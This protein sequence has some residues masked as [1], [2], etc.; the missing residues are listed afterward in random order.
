MAFSESSLMSSASMV[1]ALAKL[2]PPKVDCPIDCLVPKQMAQRLEAA[3]VK[4][5]KE[6]ELISMFLLAV[7]AGIFVSMGAGFFTVVRS[8]LPGF[9]PQWGLLQ[10]AGGL[11]F[12]CGL[13]MVILCGSELFTGN[14]M[15]IMAWCTRKITTFQMFRNWV[16]VYIGNFLGSILIAAL[17]TW[18]RTYENC[19]GQVGYNSLAIAAAKCGREWGQCYSLGILCN[20]MVCWS[21]WMTIAARSA[22]GK[23]L[24]FI[25][26]ITAFAAMGFEHSVA[27]MYFLPQAFLIRT[28]APNSFWAN[29]AAQYPKG[30]QDPA[31]DNVYI[32]R[33][34]VQNFIPATLGNWSGA[35]VFIAL[36]YWYLYLRDAD[37]VS[38]FQFQIGSVKF[39]ASPPDP[40]YPLGH[41]KTLPDGTKPPKKKYC[42]C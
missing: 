29:I 12:C 24:V 37:H 4:K 3:S 40:Y 38:L 10:F 7:H 23:T 33:C 27:N 32:G 31:L 11:A 18:A 8:F 26:P 30:R 22:A 13:A 17:Q 20:I 35:I 15:I 36:V 14:C 28:Y 34:I 21:V 9:A 6:L 1:D 19:A 16:I 42:C 39:F 41:R 2:P 5:G 25:L